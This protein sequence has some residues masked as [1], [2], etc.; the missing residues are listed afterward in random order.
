MNHFS[1]IAVCSLHAGAEIILNRI[2]V[3]EKG[4]LCT[5]ILKQ[6]TRHKRTT[7]VGLFMLMVSNLPQTSDGSLTLTAGEG[8]KSKE[9]VSCP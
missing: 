6:L 5:T 7:R 3:P 2:S 9:P 1:A 8:D 4:I